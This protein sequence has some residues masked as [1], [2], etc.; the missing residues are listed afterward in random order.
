MIS[1][2]L[3]IPTSRFG[4]YIKFC[5]LKKLEKVE[6]IILDAYYDTL[7]SKLYEETVEKCRGKLRKVVHLYHDNAASHMA[8]VTKAAIGKSGF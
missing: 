8:V 2:F 3:I 6:R 1:E 5:Q 4:A 7:I